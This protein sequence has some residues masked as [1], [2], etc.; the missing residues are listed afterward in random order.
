MS[1][2]AKFSPLMKINLAPA[3]LLG[4]NEPKFESKRSLQLM[5]LN[6]VCDHIETQR[7]VISP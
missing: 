3:S 4:N 7:F 1:C 2:Q 5:L 6:F